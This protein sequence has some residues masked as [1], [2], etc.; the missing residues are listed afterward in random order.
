V[1]SGQNS[2]NVFEKITTKDGLSHNNVFSILQDKNGFMWFGT[3]NGLDRFD[4]INIVSYHHSLTDSNSLSSSNFGKIYQDSYGIFWF[5]TFGGGLDKYDPNKKE[6]IHFKHNSNDSSSI[7]NNRIQ[8]IFEDSEGIIWIGT[9]GGGLNAFYRDRNIFKHYIHNPENTNSIAGN[10]VKTISEDKNG[11]IWLGTRSGI[12]IFN[13]KQNKF[14]HIKHVAGKS[15]ILSNNNVNSIISDTSNIVWIG[16]RGG[17]LNK[18]NITTGESTVFKHKK[19]DINSV[20]SDSIEF[21]L[22]DSFGKIWIGTFNNGLDQYDP[23]TNTFMHYKDEF[24]NAGFGIFN[25]RIEYLYEDKSKILWIGTRGQGV[26]K[27][28]LKPNKFKFIRFVPGIKNTLPHP[29]IFTMNTDNSGNLWV[30]TDGGGVAKYNLKSK[31]F[32]K[33]FKSIPDN[34]Q[35]IAQNRVWALLVESDDT[36]WLGTFRKGVD[37]LIYKNKGYHYEHFV[38]EKYNPNSLS[39]NHVTIIFK[40]SKNRIWVGTQYGLNK[41]IKDKNR[42]IEFENYFHEPGN[43]TTLSNNYITTIYEDKE[44]NIW[45]GTL[46]GLNKYNEK[47]NKFTVYHYFSEDNKK[48]EF[49]KV[50]TVFADRNNI[51]WIGTESEGL[52]TLDVAQNKFT[53]YLNTEMDFSISILAMAD[54]FFG[55]L[56]MSTSNG[57]SRFNTKTFIFKNYNLSDGLETQGFNIN[58][59]VKDKNGNIYFGSIDGITILNPK[60]VIENLNIPSIEITDIKVLNQSVFAEEAGVL[61][62]SGINQTE[63][64]L[65]Y[66]DYFFSIEFVA[67]DYTTPEKNIFEYK[68]L[69]VDDKWIKI[70]NHRYVN[71]TNLS[72]GNY[73]FMVR[74][75]NNDGIWNNAGIEI[76]INIVPPFWKTKWFY[77]IEFITVLLVFYLYIHFRERKLKADKKNL[78]EKIKERTAEILQ[79]KEELESQAENLV[80][81][82]EELKQF[83][84]IIS[85]T[86]NAISIMDSKGDYIWINEGFTR[87]YGYSLEELVKDKGRRRIGSNSNLKIND[88]INIWF[89]DKKTI[90]YESQN[91]SKSGR[92][93]WAQ[94][95][96]TPV[97]NKDRNVERLIAIDSDIS[98][99]K[100]AEEII[101]RKNEDI[102]DSII[103]AKR[104]QS[105]MFPPEKHIE[106]AAVESFLIFKPKEIISGDFYWVTQ[107]N[108]ETV[109]AV[110]DCTGHGVPGAFMS[111]LGITL[112]NKIVNERAILEPANILNRLRIDVINSLRQTGEDM[113]AKDG[114]DIA[115]IKFSKPDKLIFA[116]AMNSCLILRNEE[117]IELK[118][119]KMPI[120]IHQ[121]ANLPFKQQ[122]FKLKKNDKIY[123]LTDGLI[124]Q[125][126]GENNKKY[127]LSK[128]KQL[129]LKI[130]DYNLEIQKNY[131][132]DSLE[133][134]KGNEEQ[135]DD[136]LMVGLMF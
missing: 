123:L 76:K 36:I 75:A 105:A 128:L 84:V 110:A 51:I 9:Y 44:E 56:W 98:D 60:N 92:K 117:I 90:I 21:L 108:N 86:D 72:P 41:I 133:S 91:I 10:Y 53:R 125:F 20:S 93:V 27:L 89:G 22:K 42:K 107:K 69:G 114:M 40:D 100:E 131:I 23:I 25:E 130:K 45:I 134:W 13:K 106:N 101:I 68:M 49:T 96:L 132:L 121:D 66:K 118:A 24:T 12:S 14:I 59:C 31:Q 67:L 43:K 5:G 50:Q 95:T 80:K 54:D 18:Y 48:I 46:K 64:N 39:D 104:I 2:N 83:S 26:R 112:L 11:F 16:T 32:V 34:N 115:L 35:S 87:L 116:G 71:F 47:N 19:S 119:D 111:M 4:G 73:T 79:Q 88:L 37:R 113:E 82:N 17:G 120:G 74:G 1:L 122:E 7:S 61:P 124:D 102:T 15:N 57:I 129:L 62:S 55:N 70:K 52:L 126:G 30:G 97:L 63:F 81:I 127:K 94:T 58:S 65:S 3:Q 38:H 103:Y 135:V 33:Y 8:C 78:A 99:I 109:L 28:D 85:E 136:I 6:F 29:N 77:L